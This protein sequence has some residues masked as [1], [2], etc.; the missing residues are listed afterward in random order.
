MKRLLHCLCALAAICSL[1]A[2]AQYPNHTVTLVVPFAAGGPTDT[3][4]RTLAASMQKALGQ[5]V[6]AD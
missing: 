6:Y 5:T 2:T 4:A 3:V 1:A